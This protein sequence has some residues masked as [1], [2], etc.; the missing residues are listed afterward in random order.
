MTPQTPTARFDRV[1]DRPCLLRSS[2]ADQENYEQDREHAERRG[3]DCD[4]GYGARSDRAA[5]IGVVGPPVIL[6]SGA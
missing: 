3:S 1:P 6:C 4:P 2:F 5:V